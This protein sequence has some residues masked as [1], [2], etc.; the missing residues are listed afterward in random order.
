MWQAMTR[1]LPFV[2][3]GVLFGLLL[4]YY[5]WLLRNMNGYA[6]RQNELEKMLSSSYFT[7]NNNNN[8]DPPPPTF[9]SKVLWHYPVREEK[10][11]G[12][13][14]HTIEEVKQYINSDAYLLPPILEKFRNL[15]TI[16][17]VNGAFV[18]LAISLHLHNLRSPVPIPLIVFV[19]TDRKAEA[20]LLGVG[21]DVLFY[22]HENKQLSEKESGFRSVEYYQLVLN[23]WNL[24][25]A[26][27]NHG[28]DVFIMD[29][30]IVLLRN[31]LFY[32]VDLPECVLNGVMVES[33]GDAN[34]VAE[35][36]VKALMNYNSE[37]R[38]SDT[39]EGKVTSVWLNTGFLYFKHSKE[40]IRLIQDFMKDE[41]RIVGTDDQ[42][43]FNVY[44]EKKRTKENSKINHLDNPNQCSLV[45]GVSM[46]IL[47]PFMFQTFN[48]FRYF[49]THDVA[50]VPISVV[51][52][53]WNADAG[54]KTGRMRKNNHFLGIAKKKEER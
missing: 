11:P 44:L 24:M 21:A 16:V 19:C 52:Y 36:S 4:Q 30:D 50:A 7:V 29:A 51:H 9:A 47:S 41:N 38:F 35:T 10:K 53:N 33:R 18:H 5:S 31:P 15:A 32:F 14:F 1:L 23:K 46:N 28:M 34:S 17:E 45:S 43:E 54:W 12:R 49:K 40:A 26:F 37:L 22:Q 3:L 13:R 27:L 42:Q 6:T 20:R 39:W 8:V 2:L 48:Q 25:L